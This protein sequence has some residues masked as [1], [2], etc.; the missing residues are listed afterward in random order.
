LTTSLTGRLLILWAAALVMCASPRAE[1]MAG[2]VRVPAGGDLQQAIDRAK[3]GDTL[4]LDPGATYIG[5]FVLPAKIGNR[6]I[7]I[8]TLTDPDQ[9]PRPGQRV[10]PVHASRLAKLKSTNSEPALRTA[11]SAHH[12]RLEQLEFLA[13]RGGVGDIIRLGDGSTA[14]KELSQVP[15]DL[16]VDRCYVHGDPVEGQ[17]RGI[18][19]NSASTTITNSNISDI[20]AIGQ[21]TQAI[22]GWN[23]PGPYTIENNYLEAAGE[24]FLLGG[25]DP[26]IQGLVTQDVVF[27]HNHLAKP[28]A[29]R[30]ERWQVKNLFELKNA[31]RVLVEG[32]L[33]E[34][35]WLQAQVGYAILLTPRNQDG[36]AP[37]ATVEDV[38]IRRNLIRHAG[39]GMQIIGEDSNF[40]SGS[41][42]R[43]KVIDNVFYDIESATW[44]GSGIFI[45][46]GAGPRDISIEH[47]TVSQ[48]GNIILADG[49][50]K[51]NPQVITGL[52]FRD[53][54][55][56]HNDYGVIGADR[57][58][59]TDTLQGFFPDG[60]FEFNA[61]AG[62]DATRY[63]KG[64]TFV[65]E[66]D[67]NAAFVDA[68]GGDYRLKPGSRFRGAASD[69]RDVG[70]D[71]AAVA[72]ALGL[73]TPPR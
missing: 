68:A 70:A 2:M 5:N 47:N 21:D 20:K 11:A 72:Q 49:G 29:W 44:G 17:K 46:M 36:K 9:P 26:P 39:G 69:G 31:R 65:A 33:M 22:A 61:I 40:P 12:W 59:G 66:A 35:A 27:R 25:G 71:V 63:P 41:T 32:N 3:P 8:R 18:A 52:V 38:T 53:N 51:A 28:K 55:I 60:V 4:G 19:L 24:N 58:V 62:G 23:G 57:G 42:R 34:Y 56:R 50:T 37:W 54:L 1:T 10:A 45:L 16:I 43:V 48:S 15:H 7:T 67:F 14:Q 64:N 13:T 73:R 30:S 6:Y